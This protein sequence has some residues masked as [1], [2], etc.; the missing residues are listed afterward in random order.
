MDSDHVPD[1]ALNLNFTGLGLGF[2]GLGLVEGLVGSGLGTGRRLEAWSFE[3]SHEQLRFSV[4][5]HHAT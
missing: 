1:Y 3:N 2:S 5:I 4:V